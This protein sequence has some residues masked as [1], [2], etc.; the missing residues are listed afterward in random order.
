[1][2][3]V[4]WEKELSIKEKLEL[5]ITINISANQNTI[6]KS[7]IP[8]TIRREIDLFKD[9]GFRAK[10]NSG[11]KLKDHD[12][13]VLK[14]INAQKIQDYTTADNIR[15]EYPSSEPRIH[16]N[17]ST[18][19]ACCEHSW[20]SSYSKTTNFG[21]ECHEETTDVTRPPKLDAFV[22]GTNHMV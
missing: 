20:Q 9:E 12:R 13:Q 4:D 10:H 7:A 8:K 6:Q 15:D 11:S 18:K 21:T 5:A 16:E 14:N 3:N 1:M 17:Y 2:T 19:V 22:I